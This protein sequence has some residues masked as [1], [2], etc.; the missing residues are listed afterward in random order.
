MSTRNYE[1]IGIVIHS[2]QANAGHYYS[3]IKNTQCNN[4]QW[5]RFNDTLVEEIQ[6]TEQMLEEECFGGIV[7]SEKDNMDNSRNERIR[8]WNAY[9]LIY[10]C[11]KPTK[12]NL[13]TSLPIHMTPHDTRRFRASHHDSLQIKNS[14][15][16]SN[17]LKCVKD[18]NLELLKDR[19]TYCNEY[20]QFIYRLSNICLDQKIDLN[21]MK[22]YE[23]CTKL[24][25][26]FLINTYFRAYHTLR[27]DN[28]EQWMELLFNL[29]T[30]NSLSC[31]I[32]YQL[33]L[34]PNE[35]ILKLYL[36]DCPIDD[37]RQI[38]EQICEYVIKSSCIHD[39][40]NQYIERFIE[41]LILLLDKSIFE[42][43]KHSKVY[44]HLIYWL[45]NLNQIL[46]EYLLKFNAFKRLMNFLLGEEMENRRWNSEQAKEFG[47]VYE[48][49]SILA[50]YCFSIDKTKHETH[51]KFIHE[52][53]TYFFGKWSN[54]Y[55]KEICNAFQEV[56]PTQL[57]HT[58]QLMEMLAE[59]EIFSKQFLRIILQSI[60][61][62]HTNGLNS[63]F[64]LLSRIL[65]S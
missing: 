62:A 16:S 48:I 9:M 55:L 59:D 20:F 2:G 51:I 11:I 26:N 5:Y 13:P 18:K 61:Q 53:E 1:L 34:K 10:Q 8:F 25:L 50:L 64:T 54:R 7:R 57:S 58:L 60:T 39:I 30:N 46:I 43:V 36:L 41:Q 56:L 28:L 22:S 31:D 44:F 14:S 65:V 40:N 38:F 32:F 24:A 23:L 12:L 33:L 21:M 49:T 35:N 27:K 17:I 37:I 6:L 3:F 47:I 52:I 15:I 45:A 19:D 4:N 63:L 42:Q 29:F